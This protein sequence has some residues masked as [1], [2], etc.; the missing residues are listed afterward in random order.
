MAAS[1]EKAENGQGPAKRLKSGNDSKVSEQAS[2]FLQESDVG[3]TQFVTGGWEGFDAIIKHR[4]S[5]FFVNEIDPQGNVVHL[6]SYLEADDPEPPQTVEEKE[7]EE[8]EVPKDIDEAFK[9]AFVRLEEIIGAEDA[10]RIQKHLEK[11]E[12]QTLEER[13]LFLER[14]LDKAQRKG[15]YL[16]TNN[17]LPTQVTCVTV[18]GKLKFIRRVLGD[19][20]NKRGRDQR[21]RGGRGQWNH[22]GD[23]C[24]FVLQKEN[25]DSME[26][27][28]QISRQL[29]ASPRLFGMAG[30]KDKR[31][32]T[33][34]R[35]SAFRIDHKRLIWASRQLRGAR[36]GN[37]SYGAS[38]LKLGDLSGNQFKIILRH[39][40]GA[41][42]KSLLPVL[43]G[44]HSTGFINYYG[45]QRFGTQSISSHTIGMAVL[46]ADWKEATDL[47]LRPRAGDRKEVD[48][49]RQEFRDTGDAKKALTLLP[50]KAALAETCI[51][52]QYVKTGTSDHAGAFA[53]VPR[54]LR[55]MY[56]HAYQSYIWNSAVSE[57]I[58]LFGI[59]APVLGDLVIPAKEYCKD[60]NSEED[61]ST[62]NDVKA[63]AKATLVTAENVDQYSIYDVVLP[64]PG[65]DVVYPEHEVKGIYQTLMEKSRLTQSDMDK[66]PIKEYRLAGGYRHMIIKPRD[67]AYEWMRYNDDTL[68]LARSDSDAIEGRH[69][70]V[71][72]DF[73][74]HVAL[75]LTFGLPSS[76][77]ATMLLRELM[78]KETASSHQT[79][80]S[81]ETGYVRSDETQKAES[82]G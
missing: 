79:T 67:F 4:Y 12:E 26:M 43:E 9:Q 8:L 2:E 39:V 66:H 52:Q 45:M 54:N 29:R 36:L 6:T 63:H 22:H 20:K 61:S 72:V 75:K 5:D 33:V 35:L 46:K 80:L 18:D 71:S 23:Y 3:I 19:E 7:I 28:Q 21:Q 77:Y 32:V 30:T 58:R 56:A 59:V 48:K 24:Y 13:T 57:R 82:T 53:T 16:I 38:E 69:D 31:A 14:E 15:V 68:P 60:S 64:L 76:A 47:I 25:R 34:Q 73:G 70:P 37:F 42:E 27:V 1:D 74:E 44:I 40:H 62:T 65:W 17:F 55:L 41:N 11:T 81:S 10:Q 51:L 78:R 50:Q 49:A